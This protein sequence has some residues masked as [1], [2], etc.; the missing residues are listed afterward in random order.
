MTSID[1]DIE[2]PLEKQARPAGLSRFQRIVGTLCTFARRSP[3]S[4]FWGVI[5]I[6]VLFMAVAAPLVAPHDC[7][8]SA[9]MELFNVIA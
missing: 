9:P 2:T 5:A 6:A 1:P 4:F 3:L 7:P 8:P